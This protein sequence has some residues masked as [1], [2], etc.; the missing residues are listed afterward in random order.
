MNKEELNKY[1]IELAKQFDPNWLYGLVKIVEQIIN[2]PFQIFLIQVLSNNLQLN[3]KHEIEENKKEHE[4]LIWKIMSSID[5]MKTDYFKKE[6]IDLLVKS[7]NFFWNNFW[8]NIK[9]KFFNN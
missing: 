1:Y 5:K 6:D 4:I 3:L 8:N 9:E 2:I 7:C